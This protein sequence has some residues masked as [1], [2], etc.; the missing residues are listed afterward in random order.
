MLPARNGAPRP[1]PAGRNLLKWEGLKAWSRP[2]MAIGSARDAA[3][4]FKK[5]AKMSKKTAGNFPADF[6]SNNK[7]RLPVHPILDQIID[8]GGFRQCR[9][10]A[11]TV[12]F[13]FGDFP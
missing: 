1:K 8:D 9:C 5:D 13:V 2:D 4:I 12:I 3:S 7:T 11:K 10:I 6:I